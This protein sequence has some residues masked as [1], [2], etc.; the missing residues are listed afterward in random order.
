MSPAS[1]ATTFCKRHIGRCAR[2]WAPCPSPPSIALV[3]GNRAPG[4]DIETQTIVGGDALVASI[5][6]ASIIA[7]VTRDRLMVALAEHY[8]V[9]GFEIH[10]GYGTPQSSRGNPPPWRLP[11]APALLRPDPPGASPNQLA[12]AREEL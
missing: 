5:A 7:K 4:L 2:R 3:D 1:T 11:R 10:K 12:G 6:A 8:P 9:Y